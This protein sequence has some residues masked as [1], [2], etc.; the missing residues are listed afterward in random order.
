MSALAPSPRAV[1]LVTGSRHRFG[2]A[3]AS[4]VAVDGGLSIHRL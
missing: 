4:V 3:T 2:F 1:A